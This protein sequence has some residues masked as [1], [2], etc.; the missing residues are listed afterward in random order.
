MMILLYHIGQCI[1][2]NFQVLKK[3]FQWLYIW[4]PFPTI[5][6]N[7]DELVWPLRFGTFK[8][9]KDF[10]ITDI[11]PNGPDAYINKLSNLIENNIESF[12]IEVLYNDKTIKRL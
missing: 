7:N 11:I 12:D 5:N 9:A 10:L 6:G 4:S 2:I 8:E 1:D 3:I